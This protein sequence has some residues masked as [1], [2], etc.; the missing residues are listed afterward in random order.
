MGEAPCTGVVTAKPLQF[1]LGLMS[2][3]CAW[4]TLGAL[5]GAP[6]RSHFLPRCE[7]SVVTYPAGPEDGGGTPGGSALYD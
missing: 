5:W 7:V 3:R 1:A 4:G 2:S 6:T